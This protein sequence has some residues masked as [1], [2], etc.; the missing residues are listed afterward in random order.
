MITGIKYL[1][2]EIVEILFSLLLDVLNKIQL[3][4]C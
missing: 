4:S 3:P 1:C 2:I